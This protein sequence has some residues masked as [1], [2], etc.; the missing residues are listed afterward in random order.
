MT[1]HPGDS[2]SHRFPAQAARALLGFLVTRPRESDGQWVLLLEDQY[3]NAVAFWYLVSPLDTGQALP[4]DAA[5]ARLKDAG[6]QIAR[7]VVP[8]AWA[9]AWRITAAP[10]RQTPGVTA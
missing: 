10:E 9:F 1:N 4:L 7:D 3:S 5:E 2:L 6:Y 8:Q